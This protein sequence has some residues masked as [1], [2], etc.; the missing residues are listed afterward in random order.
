MRGSESWTLGRLQAFELL[1]AARNHNTASGGLE[2]AQEVK[3][4]GYQGQRGPRQAAGRGPLPASLAHR[5]LRV[6]PPAG[7][8]SLTPRRPV[9][10]TS[11][12]LH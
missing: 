12:R 6:A 7:S 5:R 4:R 1:G 11:V 8:E 2:G 10:T 9:A 3:V